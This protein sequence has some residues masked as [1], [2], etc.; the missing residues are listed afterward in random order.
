MKHLLLILLCYPVLSGFA[1]SNF[2]VGLATS[3][4]RTGTDPSS[5]SHCHNGG[6]GYS[7]GVRFRYDLNKWLSMQTGLAL[8]L[9]SYSSEGPTFFYDQVLQPSQKPSGPI[10]ERFSEKVDIRYFQVPVLF[11]GYFG[12]TFKV[13][14]TTGAALNK[15]YKTIRDGTLYYEDGNP[16]QKNYTDEFTPDKGYMSVFAGVGCEYTLKK[17]V[18]RMEPN[19]QY[20][21]TNNIALSP[22]WS[23]GLGLSGYYRF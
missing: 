3:L 4:D 9:A 20:A 23:I 11:S 21:F 16:S 13:G 6:L 1:Q 14:F 7:A 18:L 19:A 2:S 10:P 8:G 15:S 12:Q 5:T 22:Y 17:F